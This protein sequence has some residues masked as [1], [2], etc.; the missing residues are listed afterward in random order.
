MG[1]YLDYEDGTRNGGWES[2]VG[3][4]FSDTNVIAAL[5]G[6][7]SALI[8]TALFTLLYE[9]HK[10]RAERGRVAS[11]LLAEILAQGDF[12]ITCGTL[13]NASED[14]VAQDTLMQVIPPRPARPSSL[15]SQ[16]NSLCSKR[17]QQ[18]L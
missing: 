15:P 16:Q 7:I 2:G 12:V 3:I 6:A 8:G 18:A 14:I 11:A 5:V 1:I 17:K 13:C 10:E 9:A 4:L